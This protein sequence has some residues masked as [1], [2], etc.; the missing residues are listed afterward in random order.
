MNRQTLLPGRRP[1]RSAQP[2]EPVTDH[3]AA[4]STNRTEKSNDQGSSHGWGR[5]RRGGRTTASSSSSSS[6]SPRGQQAWTTQT[7]AIAVRASTAFLW[8]LLAAGP[9]GLIVGLLALS[10]T[11]TTAPVVDARPQDNDRGQVA[12]SAL[13]EDFVVAWLST[14]RSGP[15]G[16][17]EQLQ[18]FTAATITSTTLP[19]APWSVREATT[20]QAREISTGETSDG[21][22][23]IWN[24]VVA[25][26]VEEPQDATGAGATEEA[27]AVVAQRRF[28]QVAVSVDTAEDTRL[29]LTLPSPVAAPAAGTPPTLAYDERISSSSPLASAAGEFLTGLL[30]EGDVTRI[31]SPGAE[32]NPVLPAPYSAVSVEDVSA[33]LGGLDTAELE[34]PT[35][36]PEDGTSV[37]LLVQATATSPVA[38]GTP[39]RVT[40][41]T[42]ALTLTSRQGRWEVSALDPAPALAPDNDGTS[43]Q[44]APSTNAPTDGAST[45]GTPS[46]SAPSTG[47]GAP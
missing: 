23:A 30:V 20:A 22:T 13:A 11:S 33:A 4:G 8:L 17:P 28:F 37:Q 3:D 35:E 25:V 32:I 16:G 2:T 42:Y 15:G 21:S 46:T 1:D 19:E 5:L 7:S 26:T 9:L 36:L 39:E 18:S 41:M 27:A 6:S 29:A 24:V 14:P 43:Q 38:A 34:N 40:A 12:A 31:T 45:P 44:P 47:T 10:G